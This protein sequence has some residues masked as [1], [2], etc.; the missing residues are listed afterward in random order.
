MPRLDSERI[1]LWRNFCRSSARLQRIIDQA[2][3]DE[4][5]MPL[6]WYDVLTAI[7]DA[8]GAIRVRDLAIA[9]DEV[10]SSLSRR[11][12]RMEDADLIERRPAPTLIDRRVVE[13]VATTE[14]RYSWRDATISYRRLVQQH[15]AGS[16]TET[17]VAALQRLWPKFS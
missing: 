8:G 16:L 11:L 9:L 15:F 3:V 1:D 10:P 6:A 7:R 5:D 2:L 17:D 12:D 13:V 4:H 14:G